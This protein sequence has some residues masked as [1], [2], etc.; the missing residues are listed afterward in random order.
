MQQ[1][2]NHS[3]GSWLFFKLYAKWRDW[4]S[5]SLTFIHLV[6]LLSYWAEVHTCFLTKSTDLTEGLQ[7]FQQQSAIRFHIP[8]A[9]A[10]I[11]QQSRDK[12]TFSMYV[13][14]HMSTTRLEGRN[15]PARSIMF[16]LKIKQ[17]TT[18]VMVWLLSGLCIHCC[19]GALW[20]RHQYFA[21]KSNISMNSAI[22]YSLTL[23]CVFQLLI[24]V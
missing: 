9:R 15:H 10:F 11:T 18:A 5:A 20:M 6:A 22:I 14:I 24:N 23:V 3:T 7:S 1:H 8:D 2:A 13:T 16:E 21:T 19:N 4:Y 17:R 12:N